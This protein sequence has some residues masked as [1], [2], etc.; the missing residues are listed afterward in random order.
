MVKTNFFGW[1]KFEYLFPIEFPRLPIIRF[2]LN[3]NAAGKW[4]KDGWLLLRRRCYYTCPI[5][6]KGQIP[7]ASRYR[8]LSSFKLCGALWHGGGTRLSPGYN[9]SHQ[10][11]IQICVY[12]ANAHLIHIHKHRRGHRPPAVFGIVSFWFYTLLALPRLFLF[13]RTGCFLALRVSSKKS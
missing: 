2:C 8:A 7:L 9:A 10:D 5:S 12:W 1:F 13:G 6:P 4:E 11:P 3:R